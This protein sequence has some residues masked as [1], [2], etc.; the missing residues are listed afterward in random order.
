MQKMTLLQCV[1]DSLS[2]FGEN[3]KAALLAQFKSE[4]MGFTPTDFDIN[5]FCNIT[6]GM[7]GKSAELVY[8]RILDD[9]A[10]QTKVS[11]QEVGI[12]GKIL[13]TNRGRVLVSLFSKA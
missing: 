7:L 8:M 11:L 2:I 10:K 9:F 5:K 13:S 3:T 12:S 1:F 4:G 6:E